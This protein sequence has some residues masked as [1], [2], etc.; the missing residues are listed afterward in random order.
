M[1]PSSSTS[2]LALLAVALLC[3]GTWGN[4][5]K[6][7]GKW[8]FELY[9]FDFALG[10]ILI[11]LLA[12]LTLGSMGDGF[13]FED[14]LAISGKRQMAMA[15]GAGLIF[16][17]GNM[18]L[19]AAVSLAGMAVA[20]PLAMGM[21]LVV[22][23]GWT[24]VWN[25]AGSVGLQ[26]GGLGMALASVILVA[27]AHRGRGLQPATGKRPDTGLKAT[28]L[29]VLGGVAVGLY[30]P[31]LALS[32]A[33]DLGLAAYGATVFFAVGILLSTLLFSLYFM[34][35]PVQ[36]DAVP[37]RYYWRK[38]HG[39][40]IWGL[41]GGLLWVVGLIS[42]GLAA[43]SAP[44]VRAAPALM[45]AVEYGSGAL[46]GLCGL[47]IWK[48]FAGASGSIRVRLLLGLV[49]FLVGVLLTAFGRQS[50]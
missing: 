15:A 6:A 2:V 45:L 47:L 8:R 24:L 20:F 42:L 48:E 23:V 7:A 34:N 1:I 44:E 38:P 49:L 39:Q 28:L 11:A 16:N 4:T 31:L 46:A 29:A 36:G 43:S 3:W 30:Q 33:G 9:Y 12:A 25:P 40:H 27:L 14:N 22:S 37:L 41:A 18:L 5:Q 50:V 32:R 35:L 26:A 10:T 21:A 19:A 13:S 17:L